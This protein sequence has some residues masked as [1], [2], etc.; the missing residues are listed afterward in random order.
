MPLYATGSRRRLLCNKAWLQRNTVRA[1]AFDSS[2]Q[3]GSDLVGSFLG[4]GTIELW[5]K[6]PC[7]LKGGEL[8]MASNE[9]VETIACRLG[10][11][12]FTRPS[13]L[14]LSC[15]RLKQSMRLSDH[16]GGCSGIVNGLN[17]HDN[18]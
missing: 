7:D 15:E 1:R 17:A 16:V 4:R 12:R 5:Y 10:R 8:L 18:N 6:M 11:V 3:S 13:S 9:I 14:G 2:V